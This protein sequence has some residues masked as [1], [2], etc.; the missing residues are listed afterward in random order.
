[1]VTVNGKK[2]EWWWKMKDGERW[3]SKKL[4][5]WKEGTQKK[6]TR[7]PVEP[8]FNLKRSNWLALRVEFSLKTPSWLLFS[9][10]HS[11]VS[12]PKVG[13]FFQCEEVFNESW[14]KFKAW[15]SSV[16]KKQSSRCDRFHVLSMDSVLT[17]L[18]LIQLPFGIADDPAKGRIT[19][20]RPF[21]LSHMWKLPSEDHESYLEGITSQKAGAHMPASQLRQATSNQPIYYVKMRPQKVSWYTMGMGPL[22]GHRW[23]LYYMDSKVASLWGGKPSLLYQ[24]TN[25]SYRHF[26]ILFDLCL[27]YCWETFL[28][29]SLSKTRL[30]LRGISESL[31]EAE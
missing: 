10:R 25:W 2:D 19:V 23:I 6:A 5:V 8:H 20:T 30:I 11:C 17:F 3:K 21:G 28:Y 24:V 31:A 15:E 27:Y 9:Y 7:R 22:W 26:R 4:V 29:Q 16:S 13:R 14:R 12:Y 1:M 18:R